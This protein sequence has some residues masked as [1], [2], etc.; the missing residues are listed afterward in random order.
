MSSEQRKEICQQC[1]LTGCFIEYGIDGQPPCAAQQQH[2]EG[3]REG[4]EKV[5]DEITKMIADNPPTDGDGGEYLEVLTNMLES[6]R[7]DW[8]Y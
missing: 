6:L 3:E 8:R 5:L 2:A 7:K 4:R 1:R